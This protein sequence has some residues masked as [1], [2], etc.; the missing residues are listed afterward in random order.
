MA[1]KERPSA[2]FPAPE[3]VRSALLAAVEEPERRKGIRVALTVRGGMPEQAYELRFETYGTGEVTCGVMTPEM[4]QQMRTERTK[5]SEREAA[6]LLD[7]MSVAEL[8]RVDVPM[9]RIPP[10]SLVGR[11]EVSANGEPLTIYFMADPAQAE[12]AGQPPPPQVVKAVEAIYATCSRVLGND[13]K[14]P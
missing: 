1:E 3:D 13:W 10:D 14:A 6:D 2:D 11:L 9:P 5:L 8:V 7:R 12:D 4:R